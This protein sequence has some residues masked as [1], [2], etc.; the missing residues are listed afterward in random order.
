[1]L[2]PESVEAGTLLA[3][4]AL[5][6]RLERRLDVLDVPL[7][8]PQVL[9]EPAPEL[10]VPRLPGQPRQDLHELPLDVVD[11]AQFVQEELS[12]LGHLGHAAILSSV[13]EGE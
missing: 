8:L 1:V 4:G 9:L 12:R 7:G 3:R 6:D 10:R 5:P 13:V 11:V 2:F